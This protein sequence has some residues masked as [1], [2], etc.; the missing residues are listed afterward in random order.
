MNE[1]DDPTLASVAEAVTD[2]MPVDWKGLR[3]KNPS[4]EEDLAVLEAVAAIAVAYRTLRE[5]GSTS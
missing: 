3:D 4:L 2:E 1:P 5:S